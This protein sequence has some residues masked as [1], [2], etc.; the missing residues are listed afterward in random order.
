M[1]KRGLAFVAKPK[2]LND[3]RI[4]GLQDLNLERDR[5]QAVLNETRCGTAS[6]EQVFRPDQHNH[7]QPF[8]NEPT[9][10][11]ASRKPADKQAKTARGFTIF[12]GVIVWH[13]S[14]LERRVSKILQARNDTVAVES[15]CPVVH[16]YDDDGVLHQHTCDFFVTLN[17]GRE[18]AVIVKHE[19]KREQMLEM[20][21]RIKAGPSCHKFDDIRLITE[22]YATHEGAENANNIL[23]SRNFHNG[24]EVQALSEIV[25]Q[26]KG[27]FR[28]GDL[29]RKC[30]DEQRRRAAIWRLIDSGHLISH[31]GEKITELSW[32]SKRSIH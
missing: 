3:E 12:N 18:I 5:D 27:N 21:K 15:Q 20:I 30:S 16:H 8:W 24:A 7:V 6:F 23:L 19:M 13:E 2:R 1:N 32:L 25:D 28:F 31:P 17:D 10:G 22:K 4:N 29:M 26:M 11:R 9:A 14:Q